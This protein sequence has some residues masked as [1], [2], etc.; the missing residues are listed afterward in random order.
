VITRY[1]V[2]NYPGT[3][4]LRLNSQLQ[5]L[6]ACDWFLAQQISQRKF[7]NFR[8]F[9]YPQ[10]LFP[11]PGF[12]F[13]ALFCENP[14]PGQTHVAGPALGRPAPGPAARASQGIIHHPLL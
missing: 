6:A 8:V 5:A 13:C 1:S 7:G 9:F 12:G 4:D 14:R 10:A 3:L 2:P 11:I